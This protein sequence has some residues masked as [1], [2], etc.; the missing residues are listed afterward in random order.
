MSILRAAVNLEADESAELVVSERRGGVS[1][2]RHR[3]VHRVALGAGDGR[4]EASGEETT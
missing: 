3:S 2:S 4:R 1:I